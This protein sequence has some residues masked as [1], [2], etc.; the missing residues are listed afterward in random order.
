MVSVIWDDAQAYI[1]W[2]LLS[3]A[4]REYLTRADT[5]T[6]LLVWFLNLDQS[7]HGESL[8]RLRGGLNVVHDRRLTFPA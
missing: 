7:S 1:L 4:Q 6:P 8:G 5:T 2:P 3:E